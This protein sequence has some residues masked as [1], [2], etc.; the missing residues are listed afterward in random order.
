MRLYVTRNYFKSHQDNL[1][2]M[3]AEGFKTILDAI[4][5]Q[6]VTHKQ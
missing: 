2:L 5:S 3:L 6:N 4:G 1:C